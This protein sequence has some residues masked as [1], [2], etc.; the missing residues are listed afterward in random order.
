MRRRVSRTAVELLLAPLVF[1]V[2][3]YV[4]GRWWIVALAVAACGGLTI[5]L[6]ANNGWYGHGWADFG[7]SLNVIAGCLTV[8]LAAPGVAARRA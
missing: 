8:A 2:V 5:F 6:I 4:V 7:V 1:A 3:A